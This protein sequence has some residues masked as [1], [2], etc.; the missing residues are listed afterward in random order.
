MKPMHN[1]IDSF[2]SGSSSSENDE[3]VGNDSKTSEESARMDTEE[4][5]RI[6]NE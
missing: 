1:D 5:E 6:L 4:M 2:N 3:V